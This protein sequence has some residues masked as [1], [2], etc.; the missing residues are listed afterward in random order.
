MSSCTEP[1]AATFQAK[2]FE[3]DHVVSCYSITFYVRQ[4]MT[5]LTTVQECSR[6]VDTSMSCSRNSV[7]SRNPSV[8]YHSLSLYFITGSLYV[9]L[10][11]NYTSF[12]YAVLFRWHFSSECCS[13][14]STVFLH[15]NLKPTHIQ[16]QL[17]AFNPKP[18]RPAFRIFHFKLL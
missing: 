15:H 4:A 16:H 6:N 9:C 13:P 11:T 10:I 5:R 14:P 8:Q 2:D 1:R 12:K 18:F 17:R 7:L 3:H